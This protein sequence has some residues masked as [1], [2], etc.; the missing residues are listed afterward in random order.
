[1][2][3]KKTRLE[4]TERD[5]CWYAKAGSIDL[6]IVVH[7]AQYLAYVNRKIATTVRSLDRAKEVAENNLK[8][9]CE[10]WAE[11]ARA[12]GMPLSTAPQPMYAAP[13]YYTPMVAKNP[14]QKGQRKC[15][16]N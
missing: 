5:G 10:K 9:E 6:L 13:T 2:S 12:L 11:A 15:P 16:I 7:D 1:M 4:W 8:A 3:E 14:T